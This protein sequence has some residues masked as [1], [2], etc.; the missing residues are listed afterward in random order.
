MYA[1]QEERNTL[2]APSQS[3]L[4]PFYFPDAILEAQPKA[5]M[6]LDCAFAALSALLGRF[7]VLKY[8]FEKY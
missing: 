2:H 6:N 5:T 1:F 4:P 7:L 3:N 8:N